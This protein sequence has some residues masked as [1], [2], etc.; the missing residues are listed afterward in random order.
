MTDLMPD[1]TRLLDAL[2]VTWTPAEMTQAQNWTVR[3]GLGGG[4]RVSAA[5]GSGDVQVAVEAMARMGQVPLFQ[6]KPGQVE[7]DA[8]LEAEG[9]RLHEPVVFYAAP[10]GRMMGEQSH[11]AAAYRCHCRPAIMEEIWREGGIGPE[12]LAIMDRVIAPK[13][14][15]LSRAGDRPAGTAFVAVDREIAM[16]HAIEVLSQYR[17][18]GSAT[19]LLEVAA[20]FASEHGAEWLTLAVT[21][22][23]TGARALYERLGMAECGEYHYRI[24]TGDPT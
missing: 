1:S 9:Y 18:K 4:N 8:E 22:A 14:L 17:R 6:L 16:I 19:L 10:V 3:R 15:L 23:N 7:L 13:Q 5:S 21:R 12:R 2:D 24:K 11:M 20:R